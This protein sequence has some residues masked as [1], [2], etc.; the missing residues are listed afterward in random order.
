MYTKTS[1][2]TPATYY[3]SQRLLFAQYVQNNNHFSH[4][5]QNPQLPTQFQSFEED[6]SVSR[7]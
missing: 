5:V 4:I 6:D 1:K 2:T 7:K 3:T